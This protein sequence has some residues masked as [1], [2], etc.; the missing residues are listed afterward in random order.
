[1]KMVIIPSP[2]G[3][4][5]SQMLELNHKNISCQC[6]F[7]QY[8]TTLQC[9]LFIVFEIYHYFTVVI[10]YWQLIYSVK[11]LNNLKMCLLQSFRRNLNSVSKY[12]QN[13]QE[14]KVPNNLKF[15]SRAL[16]ENLRRF[17][18]RPKI[19]RGPI[20]SQLSPL[21]VSEDIS[22]VSKCAQICQETKVKVK[23]QIL[24][25]AFFIKE[26]LSTFIL[27]LYILT[28]STV[29]SILFPNDLQEQYLRQNC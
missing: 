20:I 14:N 18:R 10:I 12:A 19:K 5:V 27:F 1:M 7:F 9:Y 3:V 28:L 22:T 21:D 4:K 23:Y 24:S 16:E 29:V 26:L 17:A 15:V 6:L 13:C 8:T 25:Q 2:E 11:R